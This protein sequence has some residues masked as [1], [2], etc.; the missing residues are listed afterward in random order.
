MRKSRKLIPCGSLIPKGSLPPLKRNACFTLG[1]RKGEIIH[2]LQVHQDKW[3]VEQEF[4]LMSKQVQK[5]YVGIFFILMWQN[6]L[7]DLEFITVMEEINKLH[8]Y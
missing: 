8:K 1:R 2:S 7:I 6:F 3:E 4:K 5:E